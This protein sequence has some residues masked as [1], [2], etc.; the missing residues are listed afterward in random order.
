VLTERR[1]HPRVRVLLDG[2]WRAMS[3]GGFFRLADLS[4]GGCFLQ[5]PRAPATGQHG[6][7]TIYFKHDG[8]MVLEGEIVRVSP[9]VGFGVRFPQLTS[10]HEF[11]LSIQLET[12][13]DQEH[14]DR[15]PVHAY[16]WKTRAAPTPAP[17]I[18][19]PP[20]E[21]EDEKEEESDGPG[22]PKIPP[23]EGTD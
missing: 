22:T 2:H 4:L 15:F 13:K 7:L 9:P 11:Q 5:S 21:K 10:S 6:T 17:P 3:A 20:D 18:S 19:D 23:R 16:I 14:A 12:L 1:K 8:P